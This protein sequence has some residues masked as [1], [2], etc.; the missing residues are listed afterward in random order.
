MIKSRSGSWPTK[1]A[2]TEASHPTWGTVELRKEGLK[3]S[4]QVV[5]GFD[6]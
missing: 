3:C 6:S 2:S 5:G 1:P 4:F